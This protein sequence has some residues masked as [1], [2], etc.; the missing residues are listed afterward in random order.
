MQCEV[1]AVS[2]DEVRAA[3][4]DWSLPRPAL[5][6]LSSRDLGDVFRDIERVA[7]AL[8]AP[9]RA[10]QLVDRMRNGMDAVTQKARTEKDR[11]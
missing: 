8:G 10:R 7:A 2:L 6:A 4:A 3:L 1:C 11:G 9:E 5:V